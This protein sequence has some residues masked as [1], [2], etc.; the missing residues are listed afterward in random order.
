[1]VAQKTHKNSRIAQ[2]SYKK[3]QKMSSLPPSPSTSPPAPHSYHGPNTAATPIAA[4][5]DVAVGDPA[6][7][8][9]PIYFFGAGD[10]IF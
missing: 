5:E 3:P 6:Q 1:M 9:L 10:L 7:L 4:P 8:F 2:K